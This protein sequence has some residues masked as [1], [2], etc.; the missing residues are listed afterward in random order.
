MDR[1]VELNLENIEKEHIC[2]AISDKKGEN[3]VKSKKDWLKDRIEEG[4]VF[5]KLDVRGKVFIEYMPAEYAW[6][7][8]EAKGY[9]YVN[10]F[11]VS[12]K[13]KGEGNANKLLNY[14]IEDAKEKG[15]K[16][17]VILSSEKKKPF[18]SEPKYLKYKG[19][20][21]A[22]KA[23]PY[24][25]LLYYPFDESDEK[26][27]FK[28]NVKE[29]VIDSKKWTLYYTN[30]CPHTE[31]YALKLVEDAKKKNVKIDL[32]KITNRNEAQKAPNPF[33]TYSLFYNGEFITNEIL[34]EK[35][36]EK[37]LSKI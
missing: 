22:D 37:I 16:G 27:K 28:E 23:K 11:W 13:Y 5:A 24:Y 34:T 4:L 21:I 20:K 33:T 26:P 8:I 36:F 14:C 7:P 9:M 3:R 12:G 2:C 19:F 15:K 35:S 25:E 10:C 29:G 31:K 18:L 17:L 32:I 6:A 30:Q 1:I